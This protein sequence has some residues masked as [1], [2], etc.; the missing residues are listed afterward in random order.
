MAGDLER[1][2]RTALQDMLTAAPADVRERLGAGATE[3]GGA[4]CATLQA[5]PS[6]PEFNR[7][8]GLGLDAPATDGGLDAIIATYAGSPHAISLSPEAQPE[9]LAQRLA[10]R[11]YTPGYAWM[12]FCRVPDPEVNAPTDLRIEEVGA[13]RADDLALVIAEGFGMPDFM[14][15]LMVPLAGR[16]GWKCFVAYDGETPCA[17]GVVWIDGEHAWVGAGATVPAARGR[18]AQSALLAARIRAAADAGCR[19]VTTE[20]GVRVEGR[21]A[22]S[23]RNILRAGFEEVYERPNWR[24]PQAPEAA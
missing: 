23:Y 17:G 7:V 13:D 14:R 8:I 1:A 5:A 18:G 6:T 16:A 21:P 10:A 22:R 11:G 19:T 20:T 4:T 24:S 2:E 9:D 12:K 3:V 15:A